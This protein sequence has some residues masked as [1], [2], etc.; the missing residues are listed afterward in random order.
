MN[1]CLCFVL[2]TTKSFGP[3][4]H[5]PNGCVAKQ[6]LWLVLDSEYDKKLGLEALE[7]K[8]NHVNS[9]KEQ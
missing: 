9:I 6:A 7:I 4:I 1:K 2:I 8:K 5:S 3:R